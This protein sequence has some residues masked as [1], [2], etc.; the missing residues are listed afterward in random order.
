MSRSLSFAELIINQLLKLDEQGSSILCRV[1]LIS[2]SF[3]FN[4]CPA[5]DPFIISGGCRIV[6][7][8]VQLNPILFRFHN[9]YGRVEYEPEMG[10]LFKFK[11]AGLMFR[12]KIKRNKWQIIISI[13]VC[14]I[15]L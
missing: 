12:T 15:R 10:F 5:F 1:Y 3:I 6:K 11:N 8:I 14:Q 13:I 9:V 2:I 7:T 4:L